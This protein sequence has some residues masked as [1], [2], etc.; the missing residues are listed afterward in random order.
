[1]KKLVSVAIYF[2]VQAVL[3]AFL[4]SWAFGSPDGRT[5]DVKDQDPSLVSVTGKLI[6]NL[7]PE[8]NGQPC[9]LQIEEEGTGRIYRIHGSNSAMRL[10]FDGARRASVEGQKNSD[11]TAI[12][13]KRINAL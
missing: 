2:C 8:N 5:T 12:L 6:C 7:G 4:A 13:V 10:Y 3:L 1:M 9:S 11:S